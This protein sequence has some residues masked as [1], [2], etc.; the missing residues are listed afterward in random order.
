[1][2]MRV[3]NR[4][5]KLRF[6][7]CQLADGSASKGNNGWQICNNYSNSFSTYGTSQFHH[8]K[9]A[10]TSGFGDG[11]VRS[12]PCSWGKSGSDLSVFSR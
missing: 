12:G 5:A 2:R 6:E 9:V 8:V 11:G 1:M 10:P 3:N 7:K 4:T